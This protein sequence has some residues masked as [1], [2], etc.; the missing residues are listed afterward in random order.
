VYDVKRVQIMQIERQRASYVILTPEQFD[1]DALLEKLER[2]PTYK[3]DKQV[4]EQIKLISSKPQHQTT[5]ATK[6]TSTPAS[7]TVLDFSADN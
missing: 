6:P 1:N 3:R 2:T 5:V 7:P 4:A